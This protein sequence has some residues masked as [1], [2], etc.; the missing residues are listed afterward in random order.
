MKRFIFI[1][2]VV[3]G[4]FS[5]C[6]KNDEVLIDCEQVQIPSVSQM[7]TYLFLNCPDASYDDVEEYVCICY[8]IDPADLWCETKGSGYISDSALLLVDVMSEIDPSTFDSK[9]DYIQALTEILNKDVS[10]LNEG[11]YDA[12]SLSILIAADII[13]LQYSGIDTKGFKDWCQKQWDN[14]GRCAAGVVGGVGL[15]ALA[16]AGIAAIETVGIGAGVGAI[17][18]GISGGLS[19]AASSC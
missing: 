9:I 5:S 1:L 17:I 4:V 11:E 19:G 16:G 8:G 12:L 14:W 13:E 2:V 10:N 18:G 15:G 6:A 3:A 7:V